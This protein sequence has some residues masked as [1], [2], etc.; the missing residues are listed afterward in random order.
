MAYPLNPQERNATSRMGPGNCDEV[1]GVQLRMSRFARKLL[2]VM[3]IGTTVVAAPAGPAHACS[4]D[5][6]PLAAYADEA[7]AAFVGRQTDRVVE[8]EFADNG[9][10]LTFA[11]DEVFLGD[12]PA[13]YRVR[14]AVDG[15]ACGV[16]LAGEGSVGIV[17]FE[18]RGEP[19]VG[20][21]PATEPRAELVS[22]FGPGFA[23]L[24]PDAAVV[25]DD[26]PSE[27]NDAARATVIGLLLV[28]L[29]SGAVLAKRRRQQRCS[30]PAQR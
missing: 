23:P 16:D 9:A 22:V 20:A 28:V 25:G 7:I 24:E 6:Q 27:S 13:E 19:S 29:T 10:E 18:F 30:D 8:D 15:D 4:C 17:V 2:A 12:V 1:A 14:T 3:L 11:V 21:C 26:L 5:D